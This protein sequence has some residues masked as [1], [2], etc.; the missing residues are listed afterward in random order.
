M[1]GD[2]IKKIREA[3]GFEAKEMAKAI[4]V[5][6]S[7]ISL[8]ENNK[9]KNPKI[10]V[11]KKIADFLGVKLSDLLDESEPLVVKENAA[12]YTV[13]ELELEFER[14]KPRIRKL[15]KED[16]ERIINIIKAYIKK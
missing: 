11:L 15:P 16:K 12:E 8:I 13:D 6:E 4:G 7:Y 9:R 3:K 2:N 5:S 14:L 1:L 10:D